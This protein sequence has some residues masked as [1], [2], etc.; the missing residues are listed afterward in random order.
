[1][2]ILMKSR[3]LYFFLTNIQRS[4]KAGII[5]DFGTTIPFVIVVF[6]KSS[7]YGEVQPASPNFSS[8]WTSLY[9][10]ASGLFDN[11]RRIVMLKTAK[12]KSLSQ[13]SLA[14]QNF[15][16]FLESQDFW[17]VKSLLL[18]FLL[19][20]VGLVHIFWNLHA[21]SRNYPVK[22]PDFCELL[23]PQVE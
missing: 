8:S 18:I 1:M 5:S 21:T 2:L 13:K 9:L 16:R 11:M 17:E 4:G 3:Y 23:Q 7:K 14:W 22:A 20:E 15:C 10:M 12:I 19:R 6:S